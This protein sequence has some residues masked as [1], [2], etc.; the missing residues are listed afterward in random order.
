MTSLNK[1][2]TFERESLEE[3]LT[4]GQKTG[5]SP[6]N[7][8]I[9]G[10]SRRGARQMAEVANFSGQETRNLIT[11]APADEVRKSLEQ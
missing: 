3:M 6:K 4:A 10:N 5:Q 7:D 9:G 11:G 8:T 2:S 1:D